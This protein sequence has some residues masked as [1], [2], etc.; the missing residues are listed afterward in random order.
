M[1]KIKDFNVCYIK[2]PFQ[3]KPSSDVINKIMAASKKPNN[4][5]YIEDKVNLDELA[6]LI[7]NGYIF[8]NHRR[9]I[10]DGN[11]KYNILGSQV[12]FIDFDDLKSESQFNQLLDI[13]VECNMAPNIFYQTF[14]H[15]PSIGKIKY[16]LVYVMEEFQKDLN[17]V[18]IKKLLN[19]F[20]MKICKINGFEV[21]PDPCCFNL[22]QTT[23]GSKRKISIFSVGVMKSKDLI[24]NLNSCHNIEEVSKKSVYNGFNFTIDT[25][26]E[27][28]DPFTI[29]IICKPYWQDKKVK[30]SKVYQI[31]IWESGWQ[32][33]THDLYS[34]IQAMRTIL[35]TTWESDMQKSNIDQYSI[36]RPML[37][38]CTSDLDSSCWYE[39]I[40][41]T[42]KSNQNKK[43]DNQKESRCF[44]SNQ[45][46]Y[47]K[48]LSF[49][50]YE[51]AVSY[52]SKYS[53]ISCECFRRL[54][55]GD[56][57]VSEID[58]NMWWFFFSDLI[59][60]TQDLMYPM[61]FEVIQYFIAKHI[62]V[63]KNGD[64]GELFS[65]I[66]DEKGTHPII[67][68]MIKNYDFT[69]AGK[70]K[71]RECK[72]RSLEMQLKEHNIWMDEKDTRLDTLENTRK[73]LD[74][75]IYDKLKS[76]SEEN[77]NTQSLKYIRA[78][79]GAGKT[80]SIL[81]NIGEFKDVIYAT[82]EH[83]TLKEKY[84]QFLELHPH[85]TPDKDVVLIGDLILNN[86]RNEKE[87]KLIKSIIRKHSLLGCTNIE[88]INHTCNHYVKT[89]MLS[90][91]LSKK[92]KKDIEK[93][94]QQVQKVH[95]SGVIVF[96]T[97]ARS[98]L[99]AFN[100]VDKILVIDESPVDSILNFSSYEVDQLEILCDEEIFKYK[101][102]PFSRQTLD[103]YKDN[104][105]EIETSDMTKF[106]DRIKNDVVFKKYD[107]NAVKFLS[108]FFSKRKRL[109]ISNGTINIFSI[110]NNF[111]NKMIIATDSDIQNYIIELFA[112]QNYLTEL[113]T[114]AKIKPT[115]KVQYIKRD[116][117]TKSKMNYNLGKI[118]KEID[119][120]I[121]DHDIDFVI[122][123]STLS[124]HFNDEVNN[125][126]FGN[127][128]ARNELSGKNLLVLGD[129]RLPKEILKKKI[130]LVFG[131]TPTERK[132]GRKIK[133]NYNGIE[134][135]FYPYFVED[136]FIDF[137]ISEI[138]NEKR[139]AIGRS[140]LLFNNS[141]VYLI[142][143]V[144]VD[145]YM[146]S[147]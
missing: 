24:A 124:K 142:G 71:C 47:K 87:N 21:Y 116:D 140:R 20:F 38:F 103:H 60:V 120:F 8:S 73:E 74:E 72:K 49:H 70:C 95:K 83:Q 141:N 63:L 65:V 145:G 144:P 7:Q 84:N 18:I 59:N 51:V 85:L 110:R 104:I 52:Y 96:T 108:E 102:P 67:E 99:G 10:E 139:Q 39:I 3:Q 19:L 11:A 50:D 17:F 78:E 69:K 133:I 137:E 114:T 42:R 101:K 121:E 127:C 76:L 1:T 43:H 13:L 23:Y 54:I 56:D 14:S 113:I 57:T 90:N 36:Y 75:I 97:H 132:D 109:T 125:T 9:V 6:D 66:D 119:Q 27:N 130:E 92:E 62:K 79:C 35:P 28:Q 40:K 34:N 37:Q 22:T 30:D 122:T 45:S 32:K 12:F 94:M 5:F 61:K 31:S 93:Y 88:T 25:S 64:R 89:K 147:G 16:R 15:D 146:L 98:S 29:S 105:E 33:T 100:K 68:N 86:D 44:L 143:Q 48:D 135:M 41:E 112:K 81:K 111:P 118:K 80:Y 128:M 2:K 126:Y 55:L 106:K 4:S 91:K 26:Y 129:Y 131:V 77:S 46:P 138:I 58:Y 123:Y 115:G 117:V 107:E 53:N 134:F 136:E 82:K